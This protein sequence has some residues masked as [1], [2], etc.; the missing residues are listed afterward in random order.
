MS[1]DLRAPRLLITGATVVDGTETPQLHRRRAC[2]RRPAVAKP[3]GVNLG[4]ARTGRT[5]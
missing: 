4:S 3:S 1:N 2:R 5:G